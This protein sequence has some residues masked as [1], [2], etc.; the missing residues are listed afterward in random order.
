MREDILR[1]LTAAL[2]K[3]Y[4]LK[5]SGGYLREGKCPQCNDKKSLWTPAEHPWVLRCGKLERCGWEGE[6][7]ALYPEIFDDWSKRYKPTPQNPNASAD[8]Y[9]MAARGLDIAPLKGAY[10]Q[11]LYQD[12]ELR[13]VSATVRFPMPGGGFWQRLIDQPQRFGDKK[14]TFSY[15][16]SYKGH[17]WTYPGDS[18]DQ[19]ATAREIWIVEGVFDACALRQNGIVAVSAMSCNNYPTHFL[20]ALRKAVGDN[21]DAGAGPRLIFALDQGTA[22]VEWT[23]S[24]VAEARKAGWV[25]GAAQVQVDGEGDKRDWNDLHLADRLQASHIEEYLWAGSVTIAA[26]A[27][28][29]AFLIY[30]RHKSASFPLIF[31]HRQMW[32]SFSLERIES[33]MEGL[34]END[35]N[36]KSLTYELQ[37]EKAASQA[38]DITELANCTFR[39]LYFQKD[40]FLEEGAYFLRVDFPRMKGQ[41]RREPVKA[42]FSG[43]S[44]SAGAEFKKRLSSVAPGA[45]W[46]GSTGHLD[47]LMQRQW[48]IIRMVEAIQFTG[49][50]IDHKAYLLGD[51]GVSNGKV[52]KVNK[53]D[54]FVFAKSAVKLRTADRLLK[55]NYD[56]DNLNL[57]WVLPVWEAWGVRGF[58]TLTFWVISLFAEQ[59]RSTQ[60][61]LGFLEVT[62][63]PGTGKTTLI[64]FLW[65]L[66]GRVGNYEGFDPTKATNAGIARTLGQVGNLPVVLIEGDRAQ[67][68]PHARRFEWDELKTAYNGRA[69]RTR[70]IANGG[71][72]TF[73]PPFRGAI[74]IVQNDPVEASPAMRERIMGLKIDKTGWGPHTRVAAERVTRFEREDVSGFIVHVI[75]KEAEILKAYQASYSQH[76]AAMLKQ[77]GIRNDRLAKNHAQLAAMFDALQIVVKNIPRAAAD[78]THRFF[79]EMLADRQRQVENDH[80]HVELFWERFDWI[81]S[82]EP[83]MTERPINHSRSDDLI[84]VNLNQFEQRCGELRLSLPP[85]TELKRLLRGSKSRKFVAHKVVNSK[86]DKSVNCWVFQRPGTNPA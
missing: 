29:K 84:S 68:A 80:P 74:A 48:A 40:A 70:A 75:R 58:A 24:H 43:A 34:R 27:D 64:A 42:T 6:T 13:I 62:G 59:I 69:V 55:I 67:D 56:P 28:E 8:A 46:T 2:T 85:M 45:Q 26:T 50:S 86:I 52:E 21:P 30:K 32:A 63:P 72:E 47:R 19:L 25:C 14:A 53:D 44:L 17:V 5:A 60:E 66:M 78:E 10:T 79:R 61:S 12:P 3:D 57:E 65:K 22:G 51:I 35:P 36:F 41:P 38:A 7:K 15:G 31:N 76:Y 82:M 77:E 49:Y 11:E 18:I 83:E 73:E 81:E 1:E 20:A 16:G 9:L 33:I 54:Y 4:G 39:T 71:M 37:W 23:I